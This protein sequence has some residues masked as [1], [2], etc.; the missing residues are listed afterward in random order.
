MLAGFRSRLAD[1]IERARRRNRPFV[2]QIRERFPLQQLHH[3]VRRIA[4]DPEVSDRHD[5]GVRQR[6]ERPR[7][8]L[9]TATPLGRRGRALLQHLDRHRPIELQLPALVDHADAAG[10][11]PRQHFVASIQG[12]AYERISYRG[13]WEKLYSHE[14]SLYIAEPPARNR[15]RGISNAGVR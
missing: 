3:Q 12:P 11:Q 1:D 5:V 6:R 4:V 9:E 10:A 14:L 8:A 15:R 2:D 7:L 13:R